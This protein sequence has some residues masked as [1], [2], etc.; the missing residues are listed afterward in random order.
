MVAFFLRTW[1]DSYRFLC[2]YSSFLRSQCHGYSRVCCFSK[3]EFL[4]YGL[5]LQFCSF[6]RIALNIGR[7]TN[8][9]TSRSLSANVECKISSLK[10]APISTRNQELLYSIR[11]KSSLKWFCSTE[12]IDVSVFLL[13]TVYLRTIRLKERFRT[14]FWNL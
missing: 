12:S 4:S 1:P 6:P 3:R 5:D 11:I 13:R 7:S 2:T 14:T 10:T 8:T 9:R